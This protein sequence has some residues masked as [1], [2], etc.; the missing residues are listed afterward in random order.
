MCTISTWKTEI[1]DVFVDEANHIHIAIPMHNNIL[2][3]IQI[4]IDNYSHT[5]GSL[6]EFKR[7]EVPAN[8]YDLSIG[9]SKKFEY[10]AALAEEIEN[11]VGGTNSSVKDKKNSC[12][13]KIFE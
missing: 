5:S 10:K 13:I 12:S 11:A 4:S 3:I 9:N 6:W 2:N 7:V 1:N 8:N